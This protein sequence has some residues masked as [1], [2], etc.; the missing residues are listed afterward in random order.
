M[1]ESDADSAFRALAQRLEQ[2]AATFAIA[3]RQT[4]QLVRA[5]DPAR[6]R[7]ADLLWPTFSGGKP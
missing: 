7:R 1:I 2:Q 4:S 3:R 5:D 6:W